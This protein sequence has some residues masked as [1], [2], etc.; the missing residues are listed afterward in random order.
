MKKLIFE[1]LRGT[2]NYENIRDLKILS[3]SS[4]TILLVKFKHGFTGEE[5]I[6]INIWDVLVYIN[7]K[8]K[9]I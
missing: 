1:F 5:A 9:Q 7:H 2:T 8:I 6:E 3:S 4:Q